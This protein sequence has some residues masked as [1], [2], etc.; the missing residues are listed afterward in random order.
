QRLGRLHC[1]RGVPAA[2][3]LPGLALRRVVP[4]RCAGPPGRRSMPV[5]MRYA[6]L[7][8]RFLRCWEVGLSALLL[9]AAVAIAAHP[10]PLAHGQ[11]AE[12]AAGVQCGN[13]QSSNVVISR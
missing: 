9:L 4:R 1:I 13:A 11:A 6:R 3:S 7:R 5:T 2:T 8:R 10:T 12:S